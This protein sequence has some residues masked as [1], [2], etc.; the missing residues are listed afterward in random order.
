MLHKCHIK[1]LVYNT[2]VLIIQVPKHVL[3][4]EKRFYQLLGALREKGIGPAGSA[5][6]NREIRSLW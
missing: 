6:V 1:F 5:I 3:D 2:S 4:S